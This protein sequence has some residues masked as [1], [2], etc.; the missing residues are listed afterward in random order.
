MC[1]ET[2]NNNCVVQG[3]LIPEQIG[4]KFIAIAKYEITIFTVG[5]NTK[6]INNV[7]FN[8]IGNPKTIGSLI[9]K[10][11]GT[12]ESLPKFVIRFDY[13]NK[14]IAITNDKVDPAPPKVANKSWKLLA[15]NMMFTSNISC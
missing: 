7:G 5:T 9:P 3:I 15:N 13:Q 8:T 2:R 6:G 4:T 11:P 1:K 12:K 10:I 14:S